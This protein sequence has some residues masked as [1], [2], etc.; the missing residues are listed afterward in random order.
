[1]AFSKVIFNGTTLMDVTSDTVAANN[2]LD[3]Y[4]AT[5]ADGEAVAGA[6]VAPT[7][8]T[9]AKTGINPT[10]SSQTITPDAG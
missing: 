10:T 8:S 1:M 4:T 3:G 7:F 2:L 9:Q 5:G 6:Y